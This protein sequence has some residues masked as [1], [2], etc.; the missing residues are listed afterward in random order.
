M[1]RRATHACGCSCQRSAAA[2]AVRLALAARARTAPAS[3][4]LFAIFLVVCA[5]MYV[6]VLAASSPRFARRRRAALTV[7]AK[8]ITK[9]AV[10]ALGAGRLGGADRWSASSG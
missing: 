8:R 10:A 4:D 5:V 1:T 9:L 6:L 2:R 7:D 3:S